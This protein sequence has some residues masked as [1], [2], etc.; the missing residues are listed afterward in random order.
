MGCEKGIGAMREEIGRS[1]TKRVFE[2]LVGDVSDLVGK[3][4]MDIIDGDGLIQGLELLLPR[5]RRFA[6]GG[7]ADIIAT[8]CEVVLMNALT[9]NDSM[10]EGGYVRIKHEPSGV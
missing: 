4:A 5:L 2:S 9:E 10:D 6:P 7:A 8:R 3:L 1:V